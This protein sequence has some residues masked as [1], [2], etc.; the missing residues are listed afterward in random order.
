[1]A[2]TRTPTAH[3]GAAGVL[4]AQ[5][6]GRGGGVEEV[7]QATQQRKRSDVGEYKMS[8]QEGVEDV[9]TACRH[10]WKERACQAQ[11]RSRG[12]PWHQSWHQSWS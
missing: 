1:V 9:T 11:Q 6:N 12:Q 8:T 5:E 3:E 10:A 4:H 7:R 2:H